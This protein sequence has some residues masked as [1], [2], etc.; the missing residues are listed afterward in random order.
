M[1]PRALHVKLHNV[2]YKTSIAVKAV[3]L[4]PHLLY[5]IEIEKATTET[6]KN[7]KN[8]KRTKKK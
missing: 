8:A 5:N 3:S 4:Q 7:N 2:R 1:L 6:G